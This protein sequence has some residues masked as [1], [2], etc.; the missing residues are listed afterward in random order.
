[1]AAMRDNDLAQYFLRVVY[2]VISEHLFRAAHVDWCA[3]C[4]DVRVNFSVFK[5][6]QCLF[7][8]IQHSLY[9]SE[10]LLF[11]LFVDGYLSYI[12]F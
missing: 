2:L 9:I 11:S 7:I 3:K 12:L 1:M 5:I 8:N 10:K 6:A 4:S